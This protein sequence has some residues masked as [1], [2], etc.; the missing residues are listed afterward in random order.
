VNEHQLRCQKI[1]ENQDMKIFDMAEY[2]AK[3]W[4]KN[5]PES[6]HTDYFQNDNLEN[7]A[8]FLEGFDDFYPYI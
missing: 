5:F 8:V 6:V 2:R 3:S 1:L 4:S 7:L